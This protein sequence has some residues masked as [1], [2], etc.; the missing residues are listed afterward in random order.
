MEALGVILRSLA[1]IFAILLSYVLYRVAMGAYT[2]YSHNPQ[3]FRW[4]RGQFGAYSR[5]PRRREEDALVLGEEVYED[6]GVDEDEG[7]HDGESF[8]I[9]RR[10]QKALPERPLPDKPLPPVPGG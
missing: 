6:E 4:R 10:L 9:D 8:E 2:Q 1:I 3:N 5:L 7:Y